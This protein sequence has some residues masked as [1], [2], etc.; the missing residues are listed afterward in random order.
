MRTYKA[1]ASGNQNSHNMFLNKNIYMKKKYKLAILDTHFVQYRA[2]FYKKLASHPKINLVVYYCSDFGIRNYYDPGF[3]KKV[4]WNDISLTGGYKYKILKNYSLR[5]S[6]SSFFG[7][8]NLG[9]IPELLIKKYD[10]ILIHGYEHLTNLLAIVGA[11]LSKT[12]IIFRCTNP[13][14][15]EF[16]Q[17]TYKRL[18]KR[19]FLFFLFKFVNKFLAIGKENL[20]FYLYYKVNKKNIIL[21]PY[22][23]DN[24]RLVEE[25]RRYK[26]K[27]QKLKKKLRI[28]NK[29]IILFVGKLIQKKRPFDLL[30]A[31]EKLKDKK[32][33][34]IFIG[35]GK[36]KRELKEYTKKKKIKNI[37]FLGF[38]SQS[39]LPKYYAIA[40]IFVL[41][42]GIGETWGLVVNE[43]MCFGLPIIVSNMVGCSKDLVKH[44]KNGYIF[45]VGNIDELSKYLHILVKNHKLRKKFGEYSFKLIKK[46]NYIILAKKIIEALQSLKNEK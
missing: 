4:N 16:Y 15:H 38:K 9:I 18:I 1:S 21:T 2:P 3:G 7:L 44:N 24:K 37:Y 12:P 10:G 34:L 23:I 32:V 39:E 5:P 33:G 14:S 17:P 19:I 8:I 13:L 27:K 30:L 29:I 26:K 22:C 45:K 43:A 41:P 11:I 35:E 36:L 25:Y 31:F 42:S 20:N 28:K 40:D 6:I 46:Y